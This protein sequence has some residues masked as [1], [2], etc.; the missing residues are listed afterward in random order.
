MVIT[1]SPTG[2]CQES[3]KF[4]GL[5]RRL[6]AH[7]GT[8]PSSRAR[9][10]AALGVSTDKDSEKRQRNA[11][12]GFAKRVGFGIVE[13][14]YDAAVSGADPIETRAGFAALLDRIEGNG[15]R[16]VIVEDASR[17]RATP[18]ES[19]GCR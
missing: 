13:V 15:V 9:A 7:M 2:S 11:I 18:G 8:D 16:T 12:Q 3:G 14:F 1:G 6:A 17:L 10:E 5:Y 19:P 4:D